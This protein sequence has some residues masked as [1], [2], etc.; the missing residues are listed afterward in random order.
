MEINV[1]KLQKQKIKV[2]DSKGKFI[3]AKEER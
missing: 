3:A 2:I 1:S